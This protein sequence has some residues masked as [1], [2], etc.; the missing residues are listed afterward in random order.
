M[1]ELL[2]ISWP[3]RLLIVAAALL[4]AFVIILIFPDATNEQD[5]IE[6]SVYD[7]DM[8]KLERQALDKAFADH[9]GLLYSVWMKD[10]ISGPSRAQVGAGHARRA[11]VDVRKAHDARDRQR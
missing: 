2:N 6:P 8:L 5:R 4:L 1:I 10:P 11:Y 3:Y 7:G 9:M